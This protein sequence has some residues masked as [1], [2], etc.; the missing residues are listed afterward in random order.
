MTNRP[1]AAR[2]IPPGSRRTAET[3]IWATKI[4]TAMTDGDGGATA[5]SWWKAVPPRR[6]AV[7]VDIWAHS[8]LMVVSAALANAMRRSSR[9]HVRGRRPW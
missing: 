2:L 4:P 6:M 8:Q 9:E 5:S 7:A 1:P 3:A